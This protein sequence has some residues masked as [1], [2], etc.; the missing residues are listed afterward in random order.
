M[1]AYIKRSIWLV[2][3]LFGWLL[4]VLPIQAASFDCAKAQSKVEKLICDNQE[5]SKLD[6]E[7]ASL[8]SEVFKK[9]PDEFALKSRQR[10]W[11]KAR[12]LCGDAP[13]LHRYYQGRIAELK[14]ANVFKN[15]ERYA[16]LMSKDDELCT[17]MLQVFNDD[18]KK[19]GWNGD[20]H[21]EEH[22]EFKRIPWQPAQFSSVIN[23]RVEYTNV[24]GALF[25]FNNDGVQD[26]VV[27]WKASLSNARADLLFM[28][29]SE[30]AEKKKRTDF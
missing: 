14:E 26:F 27:R 1:S 3:T 20:A 22:E 13:C 9:F 16:L 4:L 2:I 7:I 24:E 10:E 17:H 12:N 18:L 30:M 28:L 19:Y 15:E 5:I 25:D 6:E 23:G 29:G 21:Q 11:L 8:Y